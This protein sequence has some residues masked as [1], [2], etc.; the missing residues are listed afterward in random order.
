MKRNSLILVLLVLCCLVSC[1]RKDGYYRIEKP[2]IFRGEWF[3][4]YNRAL[5]LIQEGKHQQAE[6]DL[7]SAIA[8]L[9]RD[10]WEERTYGVHFI[11]Y[12]A[13]RE[14]GILLFNQ[15]RLDESLVE[16]ETSLKQADSG[17]TKF[18]LNRVHRELIS[19][20][21]LDAT[22]PSITLETPDDNSTVPDYSV[23]LKGSAEDDTLVFAVRINGEPV[24]IEL[25]EP[26]V[27]FE[28]VVP[29]QSGSN[30]IELEVEDIVGRKTKRTLR[31][32]ADREPPLLLVHQT[33]LRRGSFHLVATLEDP[34]GLRSARFGSSVLELEGHASY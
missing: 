29:L 22:E 34:G 14:L 24:F 9:D 33:E 7:R 16:L 13:H 26:T 28:R 18:Y 5:W 3:D 1:A 31:V 15:G 27:D 30:E 12:F 21:G 4:Y 8:D 32:G 17:R 6:G 11:E 20:K 23:V 25:A 2:R 19:S 10:T